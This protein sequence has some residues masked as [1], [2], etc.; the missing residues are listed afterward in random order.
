MK[1]KELFESSEKSILSEY[2]GQPEHNVLGFDCS[3]KGMT[4]LEGASKSY[5]SGFYCFSNHLKSLKGAPEKVNGTF[6]CC[7]NQIDSLEFAPS[8][9]K[10]DFYCID[11]QLTNLH[12]IHK[13]IKHVG[14]EIHFTSN[15]IVSHV[16]GLLLIEG[17]T[18]VNL[19]ASGPKGLVQKIINKHLDERDVF[20]CQEELIDAGLEEFAQL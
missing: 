18:Y 19:G 2:G 7:D 15:P 10:N 3:D 17:V 13:I 16:L 11:N 1:L 5:S 6:D 8:Y 12:N 4:S 9:I 14:G 20:A